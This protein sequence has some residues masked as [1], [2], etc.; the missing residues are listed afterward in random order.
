MN[1]LGGAILQPHDFLPSLASCWGL[2]CFLVSDLILEIPAFTA[3]KISSV[4][5]IDTTLK[6]L[7]FHSGGVGPKAFLTISH[8]LVLLWPHVSISWPLSLASAISFPFPVFLMGMS[9]MDWHEH[10]RCLPSKEQQSAGGMPVSSNLLSRSLSLVTGYSPSK[11][12]TRTPGSEQ[13]LFL[14]VENGGFKPDHQP[15]FRGSSNI[16]REELTSKSSSSSYFTFSSGWHGCPQ[17]RIT[18]DA[19]SCY[20]LFFCHW[21][22]TAEVSGSADVQRAACHND[23]LDLR[24]TQAGFA[25]S[26]LHRNGALQKNTALGCLFVFFPQIGR[27]EWKCGW[28]LRWWHHPGVLGARSTFI[29]LQASCSHCCPYAWAGPHQCK[30]WPPG[31]QSP[32]CLSCCPLLQT[33]LQD[34]FLKKM[35]CCFL[36]IPVN[37]PFYNNIFNTPEHLLHFCVH[38]FIFLKEYL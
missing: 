2:K 1:A 34:P 5:I 19:G 31:Y 28:F 33:L 17:S 37:G 32:L 27:S 38:I 15:E 30:Q 3:P 29:S 8:S 12:Q 25:H 11:T 10:Q 4:L 26:F 35:F 9:R 22:R 23:V 21:R 36:L 20:Y 7:P 13:R 24:L 14:L 6:C 16:K 18:H